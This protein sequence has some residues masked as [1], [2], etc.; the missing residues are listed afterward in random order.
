MPTTLPLSP[1][2]GARSAP[3]ATSPISTYPAQT[4]AAPMSPAFSGPVTA[5]VTL[6]VSPQYGYATAPVT[7]PVS[8]PF[9][10]SYPGQL[11]SGYGG[12]ISFRNAG[13]HSSLATKPF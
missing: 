3:L 8:V 13:A 1:T 10:T 2:M 12:N 4:Y 6:P 11:R 9:P 5:P 7:S